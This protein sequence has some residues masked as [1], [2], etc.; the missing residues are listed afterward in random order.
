MSLPF[1]CEVILQQNNLFAWE[2][3][4]LGFSITW[5]GL[6]LRITGL[7]G[8]SA[9]E[10]R[11]KPSA[12]ITWP[13]SH[14]IRTQKRRARAKVSPTYQPLSS[15]P[16]KNKNLGAD[17]GRFSQNIDMVSFYFCSRRK[18]SKVWIFLPM[19]LP[20]LYDGARFSS[21]PFSYLLAITAF[22]VGGGGTTGQ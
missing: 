14:L 4:F 20:N 7:T 18:R 6:T 1:L 17:A 10:E 12:N 15:K 21:E 11:S 2:I 16:Q 9:V 13:S 22:V 19:L 5:E 8:K 3:R